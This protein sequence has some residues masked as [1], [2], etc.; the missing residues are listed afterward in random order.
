M[1][2]SSTFFEFASQLFRMDVPRGDEDAEQ[3]NADAGG[4]NGQQRREREDEG[5]NAEGRNVRPRGPDRPEWVEERVQLTGGNLRVKSSPLAG[6]QQARGLNPR[7]QMISLASHMENGPRHGTVIVAVLMSLISAG[8]EEKT[9]VQQRNQNNRGQN[10]DVRYQRRLLL[11]CLNSTS[12]SN[13]F[14]IFH[15]YGNN[16]R[17][18]ECTM[19]HYVSLL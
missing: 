19:E 9:Q 3:P 11:M 13:M 15:G 14:M 7:I 17:L 2:S 4:G 8:G 6:V 5:A 12:G 1:E 10:Q 16:S 18:L